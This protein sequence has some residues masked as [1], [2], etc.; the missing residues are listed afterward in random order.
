MEVVYICI[1][2][3]MVLAF[4][5]IAMP[6]YL[7]KRE[8]DIRQDG[9]KTQAKVLGYFNQEV[10]NVVVSAST[11][12]VPQ[13]MKDTYK[14][15]ILEFID[16]QG[17]KHIILSKLQNSSVF[18]KYEVGS[19]INISYQEA[20]LN[21]IIEKIDEKYEDYY[22]MNIVRDEK[23]IEYDLTDDSNKF[24]IA[25]LDKKHYNGDKKFFTTALSVLVLAL[26]GAIIAILS[27]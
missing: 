12:P 3:M 19:T 24:D 26:I 2:I 15:M 16:E 17:Q 6:I 20:N 27:L 10:K 8:N 25:Y 4:T 23:G 21:N 7:I 22:D 1:G 14:R 9:I 13:I 11:L 18:M 5:M